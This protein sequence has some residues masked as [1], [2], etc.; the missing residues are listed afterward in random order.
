MANIVRGLYGIY[1]GPFTTP[2]SSGQIRKESKTLRWHI[3]L[4][5]GLAG[6]NE[7]N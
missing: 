3:K 7:K 1:E 6:I 4:T 5:K 2:E